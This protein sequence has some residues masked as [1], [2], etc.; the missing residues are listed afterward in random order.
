[1]RTSL[2]CALQAGRVRPKPAFIELAP[3]G[4]KLTVGQKEYVSAFVTYPNGERDAYATLAVCA[5]SAAADGIELIGC[6][7]CVRFRFSGMSQQFSAGEAGYCSLAGFRSNNAIVSIDHGCGERVK[8]RGWPDDLDAAYRDRMELAAREAKPSR[9]NAFEGALVGLAVGDAL[10]YPAEFHRRAAI[11]RAYG[12]E[13]IHN[14][15]SAG[16]PGGSR[17]PPGTY[18]DDT[19][20][21]LAVAEAL[22]EFGG[23]DLDTLMR[24]MAARFATWSVSP[25]NDRSPGT[26]TMTACDRL[27]SGVNWREAGVPNSKGCGSAMRVAS[28]GLFFWRNIPR[29]LE[30]ARASSLITHGHDAAIEGAAAAALLVGLAMSKRNPEE[31]FKTLMEECAPRSPDLKACLE[32]LPQLLEADPAEALSARGLGEGWVAEEAVVS[33]M[34]CFWRAPLDFQA[35][36]LLAVN[37]DGDSDSIACIVGGISGAFNGLGAIPEGWQKEVE[38]G[39]GLIDVA[40]RLCDASESLG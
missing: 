17:H 12:P 29:L 16:D 13:G 2:L 37:T 4:V 11:L 18:T 10:G 33:A 6:A 21:S 36:V 1:M 9:R 15:V 19:Q 14:F 39:Q 5:R 28:I 34:Y 40:R 30:T 26:T 8:V 25:E 35:S 38:N 24:G 22:I 27:V 32:K 23:G 7:S 20:M 31:M 3:N